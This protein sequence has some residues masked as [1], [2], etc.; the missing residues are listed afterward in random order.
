MKWINVETIGKD[1]DNQAYVDDMFKAMY[2]IRHFR[3]GIV[4]TRQ[5]QDLKN[6]L[7]QHNPK[8]LTDDE[9]KKIIR[10]AE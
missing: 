8:G 7:I 10:N 1:V 3:L 2:I 9:V 5:I 6:Y 4:S